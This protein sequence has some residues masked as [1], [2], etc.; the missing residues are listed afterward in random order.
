MPL[1]KWPVARTRP[2]TRRR[3]QHREVV[4]GEGPE[5][6]PGAGDR[7]VGERREQRARQGQ[8]CGQA[9]DGDLLA[10]AGHL[11][12]AAGEHRAVAARD[13]VAAGRRRRRGGRAAGA[14]RST[15]S[16][17]RAGRTTAG[18]DARPLDQARPAA[19]GDDHRAGGERLAVE[20]DAG[21]GAAPRRPRGAR[22]VRSG[23]ARPRRR[24]P[25]RRRAPARARP[26]CASSVKASARAHR[27]AERRLA[28][29]RRV[30]RQAARR[31]GRAR[32]A[33]RAAAESAA[34]PAS[35]NAT[36]ST[37]ERS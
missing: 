17:P 35:S 7:R 15:T 5:V 10:E 28:R 27:R 24:R 18:G 32:A 9:A 33:R 23:S 4:L 22:S 3:A 6:R 19:G 25:A 2:R 11:D 21:G 16:W 31:A 37:P 13:Q 8:D 20:L 26:T 29:A 30:A 14:S 1:R 12:G 36:A 34:S